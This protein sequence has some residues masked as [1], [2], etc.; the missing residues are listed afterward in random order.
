MAVFLS[1]FS[2]FQDHLTSSR[3]CNNISRFLQVMIFNRLLTF[4]LKLG[5]KICICQ[6]LSVSFEDHT[7][8]YI[9]RDSE[10]V[11]NEKVNVGHH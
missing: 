8:Y 10:K 9:N 3:D 11:V 6:D 1:L 2:T 4:F 5:P 7:V